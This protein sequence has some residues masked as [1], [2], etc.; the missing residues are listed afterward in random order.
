MLRSCGEDWQ[1][2]NPK[3]SLCV[4]RIS[5]S[6]YCAV[7]LRVHALLAGVPLHDVWAVDLP[8]AREDFKLGDLLRRLSQHRLAERL[9]LPARALFG[10]RLALGR[11]F[12]LEDQPEEAG[13]TSFANGLTAEDRSRS[14]LA[15]GT[16]DGLFRVVYRFEDEQLLEI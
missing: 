1:A 2:A 8:S 4:P 14:L 7:P 9:P 12:R 5:A 10:L 15:P 3:G 13:A 16:P 11:V 6:E